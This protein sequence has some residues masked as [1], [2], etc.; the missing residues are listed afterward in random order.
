M[1]SLRSWYLVAVVAS[2]SLSVSLAN[3]QV[4]SIL[5]DDDAKPWLPRPA[6]WTPY[7]G[8]EICLAREVS[9]DDHHL[10]IFVSALVSRTDQRGLWVSIVG[11]T[12]EQRLLSWEEL[13]GIYTCQSGKPVLTTLRNPSAF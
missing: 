3:C 11:P 4:I 12:Q 13:R 2:V 9:S 7:S 5:T 8:Q 10:E 1:V 6:D